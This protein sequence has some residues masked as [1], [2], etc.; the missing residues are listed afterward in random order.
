[1]YKHFFKR[2]FDF[3]I[4]LVGLIILFPI[5]IF[6]T[7][8]L[9]FANQGKPFFFQSR[10]GLN[11]RIFKIIKFKT[12]NDK[13]DANG[14]FLHD[15]DRLTTLGKIVRKT[16][17]DEIPQ[18]I[19][20]MKGDMSLIGPRPLLPEYLPLYSEKHK[21]RHNVRPGITGLA[22][23]EGR[24]TMKFSERF[25]KDVYYADHVNFL[26]DLQILFK[27]IKSVFFK[28]STII[29]GQ[30]VDDIDDLG[31]TKNLTSN[32]FKKL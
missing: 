7:I 16:S 23:V 4:A 26:L 5:F 10:P 30:T 2:L 12:M 6:V 14:L 20:V 25:D 17:L 8:G 3:T 1:M 28:S 32:H 24:N 22:Q 15:E 13:K 11:E 19:N 27:T 29:H 18:L 21:K 31:I 9:Y